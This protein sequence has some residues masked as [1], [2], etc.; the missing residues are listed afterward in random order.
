MSSLNIRSPCVPLA[1]CRLCPLCFASDLGKYRLAIGTAIILACGFEPTKE[2]SQTGYRITSKAKAA[3]IY[4]TV[5]IPTTGALSLDV[6]NVA[7]YI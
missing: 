5:W 2:N 1:S 6:R 7:A 4:T 3:I